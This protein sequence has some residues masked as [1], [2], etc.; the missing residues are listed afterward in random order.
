MSHG[1]QIDLIGIVGSSS[2]ALLIPRMQLADLMVEAVVLA[3]HVLRVLRGLPGAAVQ[4]EAVGPVM[5]PLVQPEP[6]TT[7]LRHKG[8]ITRNRL[9]KRR[10]QVQRAAPLELG[11]SVWEPSLLYCVV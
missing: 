4:P 1:K 9:V 6:A 11:C 10:N 8:R 7:L 2:I 5:L 3:T